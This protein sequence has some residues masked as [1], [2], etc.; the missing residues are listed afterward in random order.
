M[1]RAR[2]LAT[3]V[4][5]ALAVL[6]ACLHLADYAFKRFEEA[7]YV[8]RVTVNDPLYDPPNL[9]YNDHGGVIAKKKPQGDYRIL[10]FGDSYTHGVT[11]ALHTPA[12]ALEGVLND[13]LAKARTERE[14]DR[15]GPAAPSQPAHGASAPGGEGRRPLPERITVVN[16]GVPGTSFPGYIEQIVFWTAALEWDAAIVQI[17]AGNDF[18]DVDGKPFDPARLEKSVRE[19]CQKGMARGYGTTVPRRSYFRFMDYLRA[20]WL[21]YLHTKKTQSLL[22]DF[23]RTAHAAAET[24][25]GAARYRDHLALT[26]AQFLGKMRESLHA[27]DPAW[28]GANPGAIRWMA[29]L[30]GALGQ[31]QARGG[32]VMAFVSPSEAAVSW[33]LRSK[34]GLAGTAAGEFVP[35]LPGAL[36]AG[37][38]FRTGLPADAVA[39]VSECLEG[40]VSQGLPIYLPGETHWTVEGNELAARALAA[41]ILPAWFGLSA[42][43]AGSSCPED[44]L[45]PGAGWEGRK[46][47]ET[48]LQGVPTTLPGTPGCGR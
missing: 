7:R 16:L 28:M 44:S 35:G 12:A 33:A 31:T 43:L 25:A 1:S 19:L 3:G 5:L 15:I 23:P 34:L 26:E 20:H 38:A 9:A 21:N 18:T 17:Y 48:L 4:L 46:A 45:S 30:F 32:T 47:A 29:A 40:A 37:I 36:A 8:T 14:G 13:A 42:G 41:R 24:P 6:A 2:S 27:Y 10:F 11:L 39:D 22:P